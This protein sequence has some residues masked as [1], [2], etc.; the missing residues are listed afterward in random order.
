MATNKKSGY[1]HL[2]SREK[3]TV[4]QVANY[5]KKKSLWNRL[6]EALLMPSVLVGGRCLGYGKS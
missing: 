4:V 5:F 1:T 6:F 2:R 3:R